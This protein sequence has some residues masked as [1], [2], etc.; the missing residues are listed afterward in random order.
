[1]T[2]RA[3]SIAFGAP[4]MAGR[5]YVQLYHGRNDPAQEM[6]GWGF[7]GPT[8]GP[9]EYVAQIYLCEFCLHSCDGQE[10]LLRCHDGLIAWEGSYFGAMSVFIAT[11]EERG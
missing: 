11:G 9:L 5:L 3:I 1:M 2:D 7:A 6:E 8:F 10:L 4:L